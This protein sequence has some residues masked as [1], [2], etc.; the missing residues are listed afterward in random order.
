MWQVS[1]GIYN[2]N[3]YN[4][5]T[6]KH[7]LWLHVSSAEKKRRKRANS[8]SHFAISNM[9]KVHCRHW[10]EAGACW[11]TGVCTFF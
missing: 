7:L 3:L 11:D 10:A 9:Q 2:S 4:F 1:C 6:T 5:T 8:V